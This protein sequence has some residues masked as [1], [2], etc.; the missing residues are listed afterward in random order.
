MEKTI[1]LRVPATSAN[2]GPGF[3]SLG[4]ALSM[5]NEFTY[6]ISDVEFGFK[7]EV[8]GEGADYLKPSGRNL[9]FA[10]FLDVWNQV[11]G[12]QRVGIKIHM[13]NNIPLARGL[14]SSSTAIVA[15]IAA[16][17]ALSGAQ[18]PKKELLV[19]ANGLEGHP[20]NVAPAIF[21]GFTISYVVEGKPDTIKVLPPKLLKF[22]AVV[23][24]R[25]LSTAVA[26]K[27]IPPVVP[28]KD[29]IFNSSRAALLVA[30]LLQGE[31]QYLPFALED[32]LHQPYRAHLIAGLP[33][34][35]AA[36][37]A[38]GAYNCII[39]GAGSTLM[40]Y[41]NP[42]MDCEAIGQAMQTAFKAN[43]QSS[44]IHILDLDAEG[45]KEFCS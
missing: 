33:D 41:A 16:A 34:V 27:A 32:R 9:A 6:T 19:Y 11:K 8:E 45:V 2:C 15:G 17:N 44:Q 3:D 22:I 35:F 28:H 36:A 42:N 23:P 39:S 21:G 29:A 4:L 40:A 5:Y 7:L 30:A 26:R 1:T 24:E 14:G 31:F 10:S 37:K 43:G 18:L 38:A 20:D 12:R 25:P 13:K